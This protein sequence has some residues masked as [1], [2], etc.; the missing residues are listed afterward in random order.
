[1]TTTTLSIPGSVQLDGSGSGTLTLK[2][3]VGQ[4][5]APLFV[6][7]SSS[8]P[9]THCTVY[10]GSPGV[11]PQPS[12]YIDDTFLGNDSSSMIAGTPVLFGEAVIFQFTN[13]TPNSTSV[14]TV[15]GL[16]SDLPPNLDILPQVP[17]T[18]FA[19]HI[20]TES[21]AVLI[22]QGFA[23]AVSPLAISSSITFPATGTID[24]RS[25]QSFSLGLTATVHTATGTAAPMQVVMK[26]FDAVGALSYQDTWEFFAD[27]SL[28]AT[29]TGGPVSIQDDCHGAFVSITLTNNSSAVALDYTAIFTGTTRILP[30]PYTRQ[31]T[32]DDGILLDVPGTTAIPAG[33]SVS[34]A[35]PLSY[36]MS[37]FR[38]FNNSANTL[39]Y[40]LSYGSGVPNTLNDFFTSLG[41]TSS[42]T[43]NWIL[44]KRAG[45][46]RI[47]GTVGSTFGIRAFT[48]FDKS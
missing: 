20:V 33:G 25:Y 40:F 13:G 24:M 8:D 5:W 41:A 44:P 32:G 15:Y 27:G 43:I 2:P 47:S 16:Q 11:T 3:D 26:W 14:A 19:G 12:Q 28:G 22:S 4:N 31:Q 42:Q 37:L 30:G 45:L 6:R 34:F 21:T 38:V 36:G 10:K 46:I 1:M 18:H 9:S 7:I 35:L 17:G 39:S 29:F 23:F 48:Q